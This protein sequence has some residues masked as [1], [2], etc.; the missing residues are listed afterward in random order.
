MFGFEGILFMDAKTAAL[1][2]T[3]PDQIMLNDVTI[4]PVSKNARLPLPAQQYP[5]CF[6]PSPPPGCGFRSRSAEVRYTRRS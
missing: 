5:A 6:C 2:G 4:N 1:A 3:S